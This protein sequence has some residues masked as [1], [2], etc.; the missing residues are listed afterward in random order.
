MLAT[1]TGSDTALATSI[2]PYNVIEY[3]GHSYITVYVSSEERLVSS[4]SSQVF[5]VLTL[6]GY[7]WRCPCDAQRWR[8]SCSHS[9]VATLDQLARRAGVPSGG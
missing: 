4:K 6:D 9:A 3:K 1:P 2:L 8:E 7:R 5:Y